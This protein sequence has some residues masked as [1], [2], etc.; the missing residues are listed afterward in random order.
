MT[1]RPGGFRL[2]PGEAR[3]VALDVDL[4]ACDRPG[5]YESSLDALMNDAVALKLWI[6]I[7]VYA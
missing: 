4:A 2:E 3:I 6:E 5:K 1:P 7:D